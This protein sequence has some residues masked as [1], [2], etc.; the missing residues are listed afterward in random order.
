MDKE[1]AGK[2]AYSKEFNSLMERLAYRDTTKKMSD[3]E[4]RNLKTTIDDEII[5]RE[6]VK[7]IQILADQLK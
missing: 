7:R 6:I 5:R 4:L 3:T 1:I 2:P